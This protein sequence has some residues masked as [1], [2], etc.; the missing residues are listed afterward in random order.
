[1]NWEGEAGPGP[2]PWE[3]APGGLRVL[4]PAA[5]ARPWQPGSGDLSAPRPI[6]LAS[7]IFS[8]LN[9]YSTHCLCKVNLHWFVNIFKA[10]FCSED[11]V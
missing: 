7:A 11:I 10:C 3:A 9:A 8:P 4:P 2:V 5:H 6:A 1:M